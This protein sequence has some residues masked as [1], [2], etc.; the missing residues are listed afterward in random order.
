MPTFGQ[1][2][3]PCGTGLPACQL[4]PIPAKIAGKNCLSRQNLPIFLDNSKKYAADFMP[5]S[6]PNTKNF[7]NVL[8]SIR[9]VPYSEKLCVFLPIPDPCAVA[10]CRLLACFLACASILSRDTRKGL[11]RLTDRRRKKPENP[12]INTIK[13]YLRLI[14][15]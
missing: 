2:L 3:S 13:C 9:P 11:N 6:Y 8:V 12:I 7:C 15:L 5:N 4:L 1:N 10:P 14:N